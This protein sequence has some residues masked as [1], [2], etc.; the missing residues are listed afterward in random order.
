MQKQAINP[1]LETPEKGEM[2]L[3]EFSNKNL[4][5]ED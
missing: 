3:D 1:T 5:N 4:K 2:A